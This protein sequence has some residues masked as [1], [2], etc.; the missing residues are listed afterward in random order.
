MDDLTLCV[1]PAPGGW[2]IDCP[3]GELSLMFLSGSSAERSAHA[4][5]E[6]LSAFGRGVNVV[7]AD[8]NHTI[9]GESR[10][11]AA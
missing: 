11:G 7:V 6:R 3:I 2:R 5:A 9:I 1:E 4:M 10:Y 8:R